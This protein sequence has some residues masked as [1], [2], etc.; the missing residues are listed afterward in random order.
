MGPLTL[1]AS[2]AGPANSHAPAIL[3]AEPQC[4]ASIPPPC[5]K[6]ELNDLDPAESFACQCLKDSNFSRAAVAHLFSILE[7]DPPP[8]KFETPD[9]KSF[10]AGCYAKGGLVGL[11]SACRKYP[12]TC[13]F[14]NRFVQSVRPGFEYSSLSLFQ[15]LRTGVHKDS[16][17]ASEDNLLIPISDFEGGGIWLE[18]PGSDVQILNGTPLTGQNLPVHPCLQFPAYDKHH[19]TL[20]WK[21]AR[22]VLV[23]YSVDRLWSLN[24]RDREV[25]QSLG[26]PVPPRLLETSTS[27]PPPEPASLAPKTNEFL[28]RLKQRVGG[29]QCRDL[30][31]IE[32]FAGSAGLCRALKQCGYSQSLAVDKVASPLARAPIVTLDLCQP[33]SLAILLDLIERDCVAGIHLAPPCGTSS[34]KAF[35]LRNFPKRECCVGGVCLTGPPSPEQVLLF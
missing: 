24:P 33:G 17:N 15:D 29:K 20:P 13:A 4:S 3:H 6:S 25:A 27:A 8:A 35:R 16:R 26:F 28:Q 7:K 34:R 22:L 5:A 12:V 32:V 31:F 23:A 2:V 14:L 30:I 9:A 19:C 18:G 21:G 11:R 10:S 1:H